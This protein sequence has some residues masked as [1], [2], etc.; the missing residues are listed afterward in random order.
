MSSRIA[1]VDQQ[2][3][4]AAVGHQQEP[5]KHGEALLAGAAAA[6]APIAA[7]GVA[8]QAAV[9]TDSTS[10]VTAQGPF[11][12]AVDALASAPTHQAATV[13]RPCTGSCSPLAAHRSPP[14]SAEG[15]R[16]CSATPTVPAQQVGPASNQQPADADLP[17]AGLTQA[18]DTLTLLDAVMQAAFPQ[19]RQAGAAE[20]PSIARLTRDALQV[21]TRLELPALVPASF[22]PAHNLAHA[23]IRCGRHC[24]CGWLAHQLV[25]QTL[26]CCRALEAGDRGAEFAMEAVSH[27][28]E[29]SAVA[30]L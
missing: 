13:A 11:K 15:I 16:I 2:M 30:A 17:M 25:E 19:V 3:S 24:L 20:P 18:P 10:N 14:Q 21:R 27:A 26:R 29:I 4:R 12:T 28:L 22:G 7:H 23:L 6:E 5:G 1:H 8:K 9:L